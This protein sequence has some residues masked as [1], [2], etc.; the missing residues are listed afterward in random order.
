MRMWRSEMHAEE[1]LELAREQCC[2]PIDESGVILFPYLEIDANPQT[3]IHLF[4]SFG[5][6][7]DPHWGWHVMG[8]YNPYGALCLFREQLSSMSAL[9]YDAPS[10]MRGFLLP[11]KGCRDVLAVLYEHQDS[12][13]LTANLITRRLH[14]QNPLPQYSIPVAYHGI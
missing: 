12:L 7:V 1:D 10:T 8:V 2:F 14:L 6:L 5:F 4:R 13:S 3:L 9:I 11:Y